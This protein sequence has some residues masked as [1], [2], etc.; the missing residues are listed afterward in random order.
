M[1]EEIDAAAQTLDRFR[2]KCECRRIAVEFECGG[3][4]GKASNA[5]EAEFESCFLV[6]EA[7]CGEV[8]TVEKISAGQVVE[9]ETAKVVLIPKD[10]ICSI[11]LIKP[12]I[13]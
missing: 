13:D 3:W 4:C 11:E 10:K 2:K 7:P 9:V 5:A 1:A 6:L 12:V 8:I